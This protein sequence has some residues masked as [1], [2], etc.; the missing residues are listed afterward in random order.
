[1]YS[2]NGVLQIYQKKFQN[3]PMGLLPILHL[4]GRRRPNSMTV[5]RWSTTEQLLHY[6]V[7]F[8]QKDVTVFGRL[9][10]KKWRLFD[11]TQPNNL[12]M[13]SCVR[14]N[15]KELFLWIFTFNISSIIG[16]DPASPSRV[17]PTASER[18]RRRGESNSTI[19]S[20]T[21]DSSQIEEGEGDEESEESTAPFSGGPTDITLLQSLFY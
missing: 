18:R 11:R 9:R 13:F 4:F 8:D 5:V 17:C 15:N 2:K 7:A 3:F 12:L 1:M 21:E 16:I 20:E 19:I 10:L 6:S 14:P